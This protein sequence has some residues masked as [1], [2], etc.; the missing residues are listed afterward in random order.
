LDTHE[1][2]KYATV[3]LIEALKLSDIK[4]INLFL[5]TNHYVYSEHYP[6]GEIYTNITLPPWFEPN[7]Y[8]F[9]SIYSYTLSKEKQI[10]KLFGLEAMHD[11]RL[12]SGYTYEDPYKDIIT[13]FK[14]GILNIMGRGPSRYSYFRR[15]IRNNELFFIVNYED[16]SKLEQITNSSLNMKDRSSYYNKLQK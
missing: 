10:R 7:G 16:I 4:H 8:L 13:S 9:S 11:L 3:A 15:A 6:F 1:D 5:Y 14:K 2:H 12:I